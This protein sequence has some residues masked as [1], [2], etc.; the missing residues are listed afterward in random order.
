[1]LVVSDGAEEAARAPGAPATC[2]AA[3]VVVVVLEVIDTVLWAGVS[4]EY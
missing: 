4:G 1:L 2:P 3:A